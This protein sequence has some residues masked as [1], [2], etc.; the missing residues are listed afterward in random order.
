MRF[1]TNDK[2]RRG[3]GSASTLQDSFNAL[4]SCAN[5]MLYRSKVI[6]IPPQTSHLRSAKPA[7][8]HIHFTYEST[9]CT[10]AETSQHCTERAEYHHVCTALARAVALRWLARSTGARKRAEPPGQANFLTRSPHVYTEGINN[11]SV[12]VLCR[13][14]S[15]A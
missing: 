11:V 7:A 5:R 15:A 9:V 1:E 13:R 10:A 8:H 12:G 6:Y 14:R 2:V 3:L 4:G